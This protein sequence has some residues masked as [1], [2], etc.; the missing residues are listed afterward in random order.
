M[1]G[2]EANKSYK[3]RFVIEKKSTRIGIKGV[4]NGVASLAYKLV[5]EFGKIITYKTFK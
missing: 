5:S 1:V 3:R 4:G 2:F